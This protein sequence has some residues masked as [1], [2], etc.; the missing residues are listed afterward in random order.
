MAC[1]DYIRLENKDKSRHKLQATIEKLEYALH[2]NDQQLKSSDCH[3][4]VHGKQELT[5]YLQADK[6]PRQ[7][8]L[9]LNVKFENFREG[10][11]Y[12]LPYF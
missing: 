8:L 1:F 10:K 11:V 4:S 3:I 5:S 12:S 6:I 7:D 2:K 9:I